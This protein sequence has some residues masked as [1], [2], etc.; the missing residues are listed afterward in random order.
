MRNSK[1]INDAPPAVLITDGEPTSLELYLLNIRAERNYRL[2]VSDWTVNAFSGDKK[3]KWETYRQA[4]R[5][6][7]K[8]ITEAY[9]TFEWPEE[10]EDLHNL[11]QNIN[12]APE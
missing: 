11:S 2:S 4:L 8:S 7:P 9:Q 1:R 12:T 6:L 5:D 3:T 10:P